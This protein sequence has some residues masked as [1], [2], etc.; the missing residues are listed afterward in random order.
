MPRTPRKGQGP[1]VMRT[2]GEYWTE[3]RSLDGRYET[4]SKKI[5]RKVTYRKWEAFAD[6]NGLAGRSLAGM[7]AEEKC[8]IRP[9]GLSRPLRSTRRASAPMSSGCAPSLPMPVSTC[10]CSAT[11][12]SYKN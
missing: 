10:R 11:R 1:P 8:V 7:S 4:A 6:H 5:T 2:V 3:A 9:V 12:V